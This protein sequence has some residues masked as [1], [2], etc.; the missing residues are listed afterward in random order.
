MADM[1]TDADLKALFIAVK[2]EGRQL[3]RYERPFFCMDE[4]RG[5]VCTSID[6]CRWPICKVHEP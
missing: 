1:P 6:D 2:L 5:R 4:L 3:V